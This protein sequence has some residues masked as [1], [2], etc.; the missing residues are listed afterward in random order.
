MTDLLAAA[1]AAGEPSPWLSLMPMILI[2]GVFYFIWFR[3]IRNKQKALEDLVDN[4]KKGDKVVTNGGFYG[5]VVKIEDN[6][7][8]VKIAD[9]VKVKIARRAIAGLAETPEGNGGN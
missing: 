2:F 1:A 8:L 3:P 7:V 4:L 5:E 9:N 6:T